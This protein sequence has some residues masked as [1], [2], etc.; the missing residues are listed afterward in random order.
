[1]F[2]RAVLSEEA[3]VG[4]LLFDEPSAA[5]DPTAEHG[6]SRSI[7]YSHLSQLTTAQT[8]LFT[9]IRK[10]RGE[11]T[12]IFSSHRFGQLT[13]PADLI[14]CVVVLIPIAGRLVTHVLLSR[15][16]NDSRVLE[17]GTHSELMAKGGKYAELWNL[18]VQAFL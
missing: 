11:K 10:L 3:R 8:D 14:M 5:L 1:M 2:M 6:A 16:M 13:K 7:A 15:Y 12:M 18:Q 17:C 4:L 9:R